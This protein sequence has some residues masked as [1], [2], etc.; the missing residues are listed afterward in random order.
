MRHISSRLSF[1]PHS[2]KILGRPKLNLKWKSQPKV[3]S[4]SIWTYRSAGTHWE[5]GSLPMAR[6]LFYMDRGPTKLYGTPEGTANRDVFWFK[7]G[8]LDSGTDQV[9][10]ITSTVRKI[11]HP[12][13][14][15]SNGRKWIYSEASTLY[16]F[17]HRPCLISTFRS[18]RHWTF[19]MLINK[20]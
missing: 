8:F 10:T 6:L 19:A 2:L 11:F 7:S 13:I 17:P 15:I 3:Y 12:S 1:L 4:G 20:Y 9:P 18:F 16:R 5:V 14:R